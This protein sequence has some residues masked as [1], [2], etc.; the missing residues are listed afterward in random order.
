MAFDPGDT[1][2]YCSANPNLALGMLARAT[3]EFPPFTFHRLLAKPLQI[4]AMAGRS[5]RRV[6]RMAAARCRCCRVTS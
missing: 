1:S 4:H 5:I 6:K 3:N 2:I